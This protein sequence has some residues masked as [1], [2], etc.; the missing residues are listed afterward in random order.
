MGEL[1]LWHWPVLI[2]QCKEDNNT[3]LQ[4]SY[5]PPATKELGHEENAYSKVL[6]VAQVSHRFGFEIFDNSL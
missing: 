4:D 2:I 1:Q 6:V 3:E 5:F